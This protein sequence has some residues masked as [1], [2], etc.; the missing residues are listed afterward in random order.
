MQ[1]IDNGKNQRGCFKILYSSA[2]F[3]KPVGIT[4]LKTHRSFYRE[5]QTGEFSLR[6]GLF[7]AS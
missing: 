5:I 4:R 1:L 3:R 7:F 2:S 6:N